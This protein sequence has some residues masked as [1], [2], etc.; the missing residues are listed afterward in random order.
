MQINEI[1]FA[2][3]LPF[4]VKFTL[5]LKL[6]R[7]KFYKGRTL[8]SVLMDLITDSK[9]SNEEIQILNRVFRFGHS[10][11]QKQQN[12]R[13]FFVE[14]FNDEDYLVDVIN[15]KAT[16][17]AFIPSKTDNDLVSNSLNSIFNETFS[18]LGINGV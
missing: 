9:P 8:E 10:G 14:V 1:E 18:K 11:N 12:I 17:K 4:S 2:K 13:S 15:K 5:A 7:Q 6:T 16:Y 3:P